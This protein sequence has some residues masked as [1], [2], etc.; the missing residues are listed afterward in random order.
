MRA[1]T[2]LSATSNGRRGD[3]GSHGKTRQGRYR[4]SVAYCALEVS[5]NGENPEYRLWF[6]L[7]LRLSK[8]DHVGWA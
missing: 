8:K 2:R 7:F 6:D 1:H 4:T 5:G 3:S